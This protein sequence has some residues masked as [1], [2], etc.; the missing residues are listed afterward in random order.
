N[1]RRRQRQANSYNGPVNAK[2]SRYSRRHSLHQSNSWGPDSTS[3]DHSPYLSDERHSELNHSGSELERS[4]EDSD[5]SEYG[6]NVFNAA[7]TEE[8]NYMLNPNATKLSQDMQKERMEWQSFLASVL[9]GE[10]IKSEKRRLSGS[11]RAASNIS[12]HLWFQ[13]NTTL[14]RLPSNLNESRR[15]IDEILQEVIDFEVKPG[16]IPAFDQVVE[17]L[18]KVD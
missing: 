14:R 15:Q 10:V 3:G 18:H 13:I 8:L 12:Y 6:D 4:S 1:S 11:S 5:S 9:T 16:D 17:I 7:K 2:Y